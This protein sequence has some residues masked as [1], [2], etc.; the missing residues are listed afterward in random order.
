MI[1]GQTEGDNQPKVLLEFRVLSLSSIQR[2][3]QSSAL[4]IP[5]TTYTHD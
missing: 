4:R 3:K 5:K 1:V 2:G